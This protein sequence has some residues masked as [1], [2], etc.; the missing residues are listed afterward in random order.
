[1]CDT[2]SGM[3]GGFWPVAGQ[4]GRQCGGPAPTGGQLTVGNAPVDH[5]DVGIIASVVGHGGTLAPVE[6]GSVGHVADDALGVV[7][8]PVGHGVATAVGV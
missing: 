5:A 8:E 3:C 7:V 6:T 4:F 2:H 1:M